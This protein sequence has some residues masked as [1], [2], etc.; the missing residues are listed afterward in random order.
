MIKI[1]YDPENGPFVESS[2]DKDLDANE[3]EVA[4]F[5]H[6]DSVL[7]DNGITEDF[8][9]EQRSSSYVSAIFRG[10]D[11][12]RMKFTDRA[13]WISLDM[14]G[15]EAEHNDNFLFAAQKNKS[16]RHWKAKIDSLEDLIH[17]DE[18]FLKIC[19]ETQEF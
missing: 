13:K 8:H 14:W 3:N 6:F 4:I 18:L 11:V 12:L 16:Q 19:R 17:F 1:G 5:K 2:L 10:S 15:Q 7:K 9:L